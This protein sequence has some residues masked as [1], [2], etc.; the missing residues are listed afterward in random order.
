MET[1]TEPQAL[2]LPKKPSDK[3]VKLRQ[4]AERAAKL[5]EGEKKELVAE[6]DPFG[7]YILKVRAIRG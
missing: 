2:S 7:G 3:L 1:V 4:L 6:R 5:G